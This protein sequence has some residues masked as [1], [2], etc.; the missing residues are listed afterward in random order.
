MAG[1]RFPVV[2]IS[3]DTSPVPPWTGTQVNDLW[4]EDLLH[5]HC[6]IFA[7]FSSVNAFLSIMDVV[8]YSI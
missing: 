4:H 2:T 8:V 7:G 5:L 3:C 6:S 1:A